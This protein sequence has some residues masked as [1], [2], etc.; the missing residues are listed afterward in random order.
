[1]AERAFAWLNR[2]RLLRVRYERRA[3]IHQAFLTLG[4]VL[5][6]HNHLQR[7]CWMLLGCKEGGNL[8]EELPCEITDRADLPRE[9]FAGAG[10]CRHAKHRRL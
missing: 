10:M 8:L 2:F 1:M 5:I 9:F 3:D 7:F 6:C 4:C